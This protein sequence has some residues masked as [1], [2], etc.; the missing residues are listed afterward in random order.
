MKSNDS[1]RVKI[2]ITSQSKMDTKFCKKC[3]CDLELSKFRWVPS[4]WKYFS[5]C[6]NCERAYRRKVDYDRYHNNPQRRKAVN[7]S[8]R[9]RFK[10]R[11]VF[12]HKTERRMKK[13]WYYNKPCTVCGADWNIV[14]HHPDYNFWNEV[15]PCCKQC[16]SAIHRGEITNY[17]TINLKSTK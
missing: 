15:V 3:S 17:K 11:A 1:S 10:K 13:L 16:H 6:I 14:A 9:E 7:E 2:Y 5:W 8:G 12:Y 4:K